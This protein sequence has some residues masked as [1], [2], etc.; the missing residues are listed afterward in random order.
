MEANSRLKEIGI[1]SEILYY[2]TIKPFDEMALSMSVTK[3]RKVLVIEEA[4]A[5]DG[6]FNYVLRAAKHISNVEYGQIAVDDFVHQY[7]TYS[8]LCDDLGFSVAGILKKIEK[9][10][11]FDR[12]LTIS[13]V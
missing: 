6:V 11:A 3:T 8:E 2:P 13:G 9:C 7:G 1:E 4:S 5:H 10:F 12:V